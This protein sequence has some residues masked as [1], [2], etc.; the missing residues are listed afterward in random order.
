MSPKQYVAIAVANAKGLDKQPWE[1]RINWVKDN[2]SN[3]EQLEPKDS[4][5]FLYRKG[6]KALRDSD[7][8][9]EV[10]YIM[11]L[12]C[13]NSGC[14]L[15]AVLAKNSITAINSNVL[16]TSRNDVYGK[17]MENIGDA[18]LT[19]KQVKEAT[20]PALYGSIAEPKKLLGDN[21]PEYHAFQKGLNAAVPAL[22]FLS[23]V[24]R[25][26]WR[27]DVTHYGWILP[28]GSEVKIPNLGV[29]KLRVE[30]E[31]TSFV[32]QY[33][34]LECNDN[35][36]PLLVAIIHS[37]D[38]YIARE[39]V[40]RAKAQGFQLAHIHDSWWT[41]PCNFN[42]VRE[43]YQQLLIKIAQSDLLNEILKSVNPDMPNI[44]FTQSE[45]DMWKGIE[46]AEYFLS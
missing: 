26:A 19:R 28:D 29:K 38:G 24:C 17:I 22:K 43:N 30:L 33:K 1:E 34:D 21:T 7:M 35:Y 10:Q 16:G 8:G 42:R 20:I 23:K 11:D 14:Q 9:K 27:D 39:M 18:G 45:L 36:I 5:K 2:Y 13:T 25:M 32:Y 4:D 31:N 41:Q 40:R 37:I 44:R 3:L 6:V 15:M 46:E 12:D